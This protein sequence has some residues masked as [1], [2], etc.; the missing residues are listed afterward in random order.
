[1]SLQH[2]FVLKLLPTM[3]PLALVQFSIEDCLWESAVLH[4]ADMPFPVKLRCSIEGLNTHYAGT[5]QDHIPD[6]EVLICRMACRWCSWI[7][8]TALMCLQKRVLSDTAKRGWCFSTAFSCNCHSV[9][10][11]Y[12]A[13]AALTLQ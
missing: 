8:V 3:Y 9:K 12:G 13:E 5:T 4:P 10:I 6:V 1:M 7:H 2:I 11:V